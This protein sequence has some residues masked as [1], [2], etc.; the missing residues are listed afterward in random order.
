MT[1]MMPESQIINVGEVNLA[2][3]RWGVGETLFLVHGLG[4]NSQLWVNQVE[5]FGDRFDVVA[6]DL[7]GFGCS[8]KPTASGCYSIEKF[9]N[10]LLQLAN[11]LSIK[12]FHY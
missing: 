7:R 8:D 5:A 2:F 3:R 4:A 10:D 1:I 12:N 11:K 9:S 6:V